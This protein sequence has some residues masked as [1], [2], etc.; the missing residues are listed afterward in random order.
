MPMT[1]TQP[2]LPSGKAPLA[3]LSKLRDVAALG[4]TDSDLAVRQV[5]V[6]DWF[7][8]WND[9]FFSNRLRPVHVNV[10]LTK[11]GKNLGLCSYKP[12]QYIEIHPCCFNRQTKTISGI[13]MPSAAW[14][15]LHE[16]IHL[17]AAQTSKDIWGADKNCHTTPVWVDWCN[18]IADQLEMPLS[19]A[20]MKRGKERTSD[21]QER[22]NVWKPRNGIKPIIREGTRLASYEETRC[23]PYAAT[24]A[25][26]Q[27]NLEIR[28]ELTQLPQF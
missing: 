6:Y 27:D 7:E 19:Y 4:C 15:V 11:F 23:F 20:Q 18:F 3:N 26:M 1:F 12:V 21:G 16:M 2:A 25:L 14:I 8:Q 28:G 24:D 13:E 9:R 5:Q 22:I 10:S 17:V